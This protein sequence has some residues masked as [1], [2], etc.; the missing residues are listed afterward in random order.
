[1]INIRS[2]TP[3]TCPLS[4]SPGN[5]FVPSRE[6]YL[7]PLLMKETSWMRGVKDVTRNCLN[8]KDNVWIRGVRPLSTYLD[9]LETGEDRMGDMLTQLPWMNEWMNVP[10]MWLL[11]PLIAPYVQRQDTILTIQTHPKWISCAKSRHLQVQRSKVM[12]PFIEPGA[13]MG[14][15]LERTRWIMFIS[16]LDNSKR[17]V[18]NLPFCSSCSLSSCTYFALQFANIM[19]ISRL[20]KNDVHEY[21]CS[22]SSIQIGLI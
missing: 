22:L 15:G 4:L 18:L 3:H 10:L 19:N 16:T 21:R 5:I 14:V 9:E 7:L 11:W 17:C 6:A 13:C 12:Y 8:G 1:M 20:L 2:A